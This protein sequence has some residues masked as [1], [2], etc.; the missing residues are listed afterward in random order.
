MKNVKYE[1]AACEKISS[2][3]VIINTSKKVN[4]SIVRIFLWENNYTN[5]KLA[6]RAIVDGMNAY[7]LS[8][9]F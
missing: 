4:Q 8:K 2:R 5:E 9:S 7:V 6:S 3:S 1:L